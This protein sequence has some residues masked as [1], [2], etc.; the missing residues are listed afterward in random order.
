MTMTRRQILAASALAYATPAF[1]AA[2]RRITLDL[3][4][5]A[6]PLDRF[7]DHCVGAD[8]PGTT[9]RDDC[10]AQLKTTVDELGFRYLRFHAIFHDVLHTV[11]RDAAGALV[12][13]QSRRGRRLHVAADLCGRR[14]AV[15]DDTRHDL[16]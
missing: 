11:N 15:G 3:A 9:I 13:R 12:A 16:Q 8:Y 5:A 7:F 1:A 10:Q 4:L 14:R 2:Q 6:G